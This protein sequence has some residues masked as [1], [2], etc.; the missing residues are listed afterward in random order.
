MKS[1]GYIK[2]G[3]KM[4][5]LI[6]S[7]YKVL[8]TL[9]RFGINLGFGDCTISRIC[10]KFGVNED[11]FL[12][13][14]NISVNQN[15]FPTKKLQS[16]SVKTL[17][18]YLN[19]SHSYYNNE[20]ILFIEFKIAML[21][22]DTPDNVNNLS[23]LKKFFDEYKKEVKEH[24]DYEEVKVYPY[25]IFIEESLERNENIELCLE[26]LTQYSITDYSK[27]H[28]DIEDKLTDLKNIIIK[29][30]PAP[31]D[32]NVLHDILNELFTLQSDL[33]IHKRIEEKILVPKIKEMEEKIIAMSELNR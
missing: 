32:Q 30:L 13:I 16:F 12:E 17:C 22:W 3:D 27:E 14:I 19:K 28:D 18:E 33:M 9:K 5:D 11:F 23:I 20:K 15:Y 25:A 26:K 10:Q 6:H 21:E 31:K 4:A 7:N 8:S 24:T 1:T 29:Y 2:G